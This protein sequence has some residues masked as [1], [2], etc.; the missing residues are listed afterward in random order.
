[1]TVSGKGRHDPVWFPGPVP[2][3]ESMA[4]FVMADFMLR[5]KVS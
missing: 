5:A 3:V 4:A 2:I 1:V